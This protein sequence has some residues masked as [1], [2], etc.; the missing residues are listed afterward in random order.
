MTAPHPTDRRLASFVDGRLPAADAAEVR[1]HVLEC[2]RCLQW[3]GQCTGQNVLFRDS[4][5]MP[6][7]AEPVF[8]PGASWEDREVEPTIGDVW[9]IGRHGLV[10]LAV[11]WA[12]DPESLRLSALPVTEPEF[13]D[14]WCLITEVVAGDTRIPVAV[15]VAHEASI[16]WCVLDARVGSVPDT[17]IAELGVLRRSFR[18]GNDP[19][20]DLAVGRAV[21]SRL[22]ERA[23]A[24]DEL[25]DRFQELA[26]VNTA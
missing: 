6:A 11:I 16:P 25:A 3:L 14:Q 5:N 20:D 15:S 21:W 1:A 13:A 10:E 12:T 17:A 8:A 19:K 22:E 7:P 18:S 26:K 24:L 9:R 2:G 23:E 4:S